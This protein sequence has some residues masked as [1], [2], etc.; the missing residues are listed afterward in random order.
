M[1]G[2]RFGSRATLLAVDSRGSLSDGREHESGGEHH[3]GDECEDDEQELF[4]AH[5]RVLEPEC[6]RLIVA[7]AKR[8]V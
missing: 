5:E 7:G 8:P 2:T 1:V 3:D 4:L 6:Q